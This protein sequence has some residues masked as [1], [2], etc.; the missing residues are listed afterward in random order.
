MRSRRTVE[1]TYRGV[2]VLVKVRSVMDETEYRISA[3]LKHAAVCSQDLVHLSFEA[4]LVDASIKPILV[5]Y[6][7]DLLDA[8]R[9]ARKTMNTALEAFESGG[10]GHDP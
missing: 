1:I 7:D 8:V 2:P 9:L 4:D 5:S 3:D 6:E 10:G